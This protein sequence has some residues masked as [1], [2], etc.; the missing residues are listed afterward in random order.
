MK[1]LVLNIPESEYRFFLKLIKSF[2]FVEI[3]EKKNRLL[4]LEAKLSPS[5]RKI[6]S[7]LK[8][9]LNEVEL[10]GQ[11]KIEAKSAKE[12]LDEL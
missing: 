1:Q 2:P 5:K 4:E 10:I 9:G 8:E 6:W 3:D 11:G 7:S 12:F